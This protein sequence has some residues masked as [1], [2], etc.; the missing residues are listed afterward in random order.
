MRRYRLRLLKRPAVLEIG[1][2]P[3]RPKRVIADRRHN[4]RL[5][6]LALHEIEGVALLERAI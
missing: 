4:A 1:R 5:A 3:C 6:R 2:D